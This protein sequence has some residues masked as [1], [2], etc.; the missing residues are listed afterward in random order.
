MGF[1]TNTKQYVAT[2]INEKNGTN[3]LT[4]LSNMKI[5]HIHTPFALECGDVLPELDIAYHTYGKMNA[6]GSNV[7]WICHALTGS[8]DAADWWAG[9]IG[10]GK[11]FNPFEHFI[12]CANMIGSHYGSTSPLSIDPRTGRFYGRNFP[13]ITIRDVAKAHYLLAQSLGIQRVK[14]CIGG[15]MGGQQ[16]LEWAIQEPDFFEQIAVIA[17]GPKMMPWGIA[18]NETQRMAIEADPSVSAENV[19][20]ITDLETLK[21]VGAK[22]MEAAR[23]IGMLSYRSYEGYNIAQLDDSDAIDTFKVQSYQRYQGHK[24]RSRFNALSYISVSKTMDSHN[25]GRNRGGLTQALEQ[26]KADTLIVGIQS[27]ILFPIEEQAALA[28]YIPKSR[29]EVINSKFGHDGFLIEFDQLL[30]LFERFTGRK[31]GSQMTFTI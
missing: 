8:S 27:D 1:K 20:Q 25:V 12:V 31:I 14:L 29:F 13:I 30:S 17:C 22:G 10:H 19:A 23:A 6:D 7:I 5:L 11:F 21:S 26:I 18:L 16:V 28:A 15:S 9:L 4:T 2:A 3:N 24:L